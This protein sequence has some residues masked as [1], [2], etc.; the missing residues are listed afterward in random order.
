MRKSGT[1]KINHVA[2]IMDGNGRW[3]NGRRHQRVWGHIR[4]AQIVNSLV[5]AADDLGVKALTLFAFSTENWNR[6][7]GEIKVLFSLLK[8]FL[9][10]EKPRILKNNIK[11]KVIGDLTGPAPETIALIKEMEELTKDAQGLKLTFAFDYGGRQE[12]VHSVNHFIKSN[13][14]RQIT[15]DDIENN[16]EEKEQ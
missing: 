15:S 11:F 10:K 1:N 9:K 14:Q 13:P 4:G 7:K 2:I 12:I 16:Q 5:E 6:P 3:A 8:K